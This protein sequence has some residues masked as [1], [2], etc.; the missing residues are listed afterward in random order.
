VIKAGKM[1][2][3]NNDDGIKVNHN[4]GGILSTEKLSTSVRNIN[5][6]KRVK[7]TYKIPRKN[8]QPVEYQVR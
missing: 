8:I 1:A 6:S 2:N 7:E 4:I 5:A 3:R